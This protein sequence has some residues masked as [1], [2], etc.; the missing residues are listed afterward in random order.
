M[1]FTKQGLA[2]VELPYLNISQGMKQYREQERK[3]LLGS[4]DLSSLLRWKSKDQEIMI[5]YTDM[6]YLPVFLMFYEGIVV[7]RLTNFLAFV[8]DYDT[9]SVSYGIGSYL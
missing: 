1:Y 7:K 6:N 3:F 9:Y 8:T 4:N 5:S 2:V